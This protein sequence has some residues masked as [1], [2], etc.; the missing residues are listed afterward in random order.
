MSEEFVPWI[1]IAGFAIFGFY[2]AMIVYYFLLCN[3]VEKIARRMGVSRHVSTYWAA[4]LWA[5]IGDKQKAIE[6]LKVYMSA[7]I[8]AQARKEQTDEEHNAFADEWR[9]M[10]V[11]FCK[12]YD[13]PK[14]Y[15]LAIPDTATE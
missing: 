3:N 7:Y 6:T 1:G 5:K 2:I 8:M 4:V 11:D 15:W 14:E 13:I 12:D 9:K 10:Y